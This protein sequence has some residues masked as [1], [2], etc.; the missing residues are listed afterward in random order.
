MFNEIIRMVYKSFGD[1]VAGIIANSLSNSSLLLINTTNAKLF[2]KGVIAQR[3][4]TT[5]KLK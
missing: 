5:Y 1:L 2:M 3:L 4:F